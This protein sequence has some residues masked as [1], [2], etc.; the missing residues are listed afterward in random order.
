[1]DVLWATVYLLVQLA[2][3]LAVLVGVRR[4][5]PSA[6][7]AWVLLGAGHLALFCGNVP[8]YL[9]PLV[10]MEKPPYPSPLTLIYV[11]QYPL[12]ALGLLLLVR[13]RTPSW[14]IAG[15]ID[16]AIVTV[17]ASLLSWIY[18]I[19]PLMSG[20]ELGLAERTAAVAF[21]L[22]DLLLLALG[23][24]LMLGA[25]LRPPALRVLAAYLVLFT[26]ADT[27]LS[28]ATLSGRPALGWAWAEVLVTCASVALGVAGLHPSMRQVEERSPTAGPDAGRR[29]LLLLTIASLL[30][31]A[32]LLVQYHRD[33]PL[34]VPLVCATCGVL[35]LLVL[36][37]MVGLVAAQREVAITDGLTGLHT[38]R[39]FEHSLAVEA[40]RALRGAGVAVLL[41]DIDHFKSVNDTYGHHGG[42]RVLCEVARRLQ[43]TLR[44]GELIARYG[45]E[46]FAVLVPNTVPPI[47]REVAERVRSALSDT[48]M[49]VSPTRS[50]PVTVSIGVA[51]M[52][53][54]ADSGDELVRLADR[55]LYASKEA[56]R[57]RVTSTVNLH[58]AA[59]GSTPVVVAP[60]VPAAARQ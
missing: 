27:G 23:A 10:G 57:N 22:G 18:L 8:T 21:P 20:A 13:R 51:T 59:P 37:R 11:A 12:T 40:E 49:P 43:A 50:A 15:L 31:P 36:A 55:L 30:A 56:G 6:H 3:G 58:A 45:G 53:E 48:P 46:E 4:H 24:R 17:S 42:D 26:M 54:D 38:R 41:L 14:D 25:G 34:Y 60:P 9:A 47:A 19:D 7:V 2:G 39:Y 5:R 16:A 44:D 35:Y 1:M 29:R 32:T 52:P 28:V 33:A